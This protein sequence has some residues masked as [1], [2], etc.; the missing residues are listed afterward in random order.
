M[1]TVNIYR[2]ALKEKLIVNRSN[3]RDVF[4]QAQKVYRERM[5]TELDLML[6][7][8]K[9]GRKIRRAV[10]IP[11]PEDHTRDYD[12]I[13]TMVEMSVDAVI[14]LKAAEFACYVMDQWDWNA[15]FASNT[16]S[17]LSR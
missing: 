16:A 11:E 4:E 7:D 17:Y 5:I 10:A 6:A 2:D 15:S 13:I 12:R 3:H 8:A 9:A 1:N 14:E